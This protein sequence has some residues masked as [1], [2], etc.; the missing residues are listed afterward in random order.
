MVYDVCSIFHLQY[1][2]HSTYQ[3]FFWYSSANISNII[4]SVFNIK[5]EL[6][7]MNIY[8]LICIYIYIFIC[9]NGICVQY[10]LYIY[11]QYYIHSQW[12]IY[13]YICTPFIC[14]LFCI[15]WI[16]YVQTTYVK[17]SSYLMF[18]VLTQFVVNHIYCLKI[19]YL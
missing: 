12:N 10:Y 15:D 11:F 13:I 16:R 5:Y 9:V 2:I 17:L 19:S 1:Y 3:V 8:S 7:H 18:I 14:T 4:Y 6:Y